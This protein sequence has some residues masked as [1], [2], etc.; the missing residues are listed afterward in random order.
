MRG[1][2]P[3]HLHLGSSCRHRDAKGR[4]AFVCAKEEA[5]KGGGK[6]AWQGF[7]SEIKVNNLMGLSTRNAIGEFR[8]VLQM[9]VPVMVQV[10]VCLLCLDSVFGRTFAAWAAFAAC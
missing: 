4:G 10:T 8:L 3:G 1:F 9:F 2:Y 5:G 6:E 7:R